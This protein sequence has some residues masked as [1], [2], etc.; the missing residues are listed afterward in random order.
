MNLN[1]L[2]ENDP[3]ALHSFKE[4]YQSQFLFLENQ[5]DVF[6][7]KPFILYPILIAW[8]DSEG[9]YIDRDTENHRHNIWDYREGEP[10]EA[11]EIEF[12]HGEKYEHSLRD[13]VRDGIKI[14]LNQS[15]D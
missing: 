10:A 13:S 6:N 11:Y 5:P 12:Y 1:E 15:I 3:K 8:L 4:W 14:Y 7:L 9:I 2:F